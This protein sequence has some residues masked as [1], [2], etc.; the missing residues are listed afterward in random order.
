[1]YDRNGNLITK[2]TYN[3]DDDYFRDTLVSTQ[4]FEYG[5]ESM[6]SDLLDYAYN[7]RI[8]Y[9]EIGNPI[10]AY[11]SDG[12]DGYYD[13]VEYVWEGRQLV[14]FN[15]FDY[16]DLYDSSLTSYNSKISFEYDEDGI[17]TAKIVDGVRHEYIVNGSQ[18]L[19]EKW[20]QNGMQ[21]M[22]VY[23]YDENGAPIGIKYRDDTY[24]EGEY[25]CYFFEKNLQGDIVAIY[26]SAG[27]KLGTYLYDAWG[28]CT[29]SGTHNILT[30]NP[31]RYRSYYFDTE[32]GLYYLQSRYYN[33]AWHRFIN[34][35]SYLNANGDII[36]YN[37]FAYC[38]NNPIM[39][40]DPTGEISW[41]IIAACVGV[42]IFIAA[43]LTPTSSEINSD[44]ERHYQ[45][46]EMNTTSDSI[47]TIINTYEKQ[48]EWADQYHEYTEGNQGE[49]AL[50]NDK[51][52]SPDGGHIEVIICSPPGKSPYIVDQYVDEIN[53]GTYNYASNEI[54]VTYYVD[55][56]FR[57]MIPYYLYGNTSTDKEGWLKWAID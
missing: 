29:V 12:M 39:F 14:E 48:E 33:P 1:M 31:F 27:T 4:N 11:P 24:S 26:N 32:T 3:L 30:I 51:Y 7:N 56:F 2:R 46:N 37:I 53:M 28:N 25:S 22:M 13:G 34:A 40:V 55:H 54:L 57:D 8:I 17:R 47:E 23:V 20:T 41:L 6:W 10:Y 18:I 19:A 35:D 45:R 21:Y 50:Y 9:D 44:A 16:F 43:H 52:L 5:Y 36:G 42:G 49:D 38:S 15:R